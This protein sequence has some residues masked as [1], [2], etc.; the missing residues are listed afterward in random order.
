MRMKMEN[1]LYKIA[2][3][4]ICNC[5]HH[6]LLPADSTC[7]VCMGVTLQSSEID[8]LIASAPS[9]QYDQSYFEALERMFESFE[10]AA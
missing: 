3:T 7:E 2:D 10:Y 9:D 8:E 6:L 5:S 4:M 1:R